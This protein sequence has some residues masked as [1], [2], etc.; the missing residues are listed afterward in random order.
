MNKYAAIFFDLDGTLRANQPEGFEAF[1]EYAAQ[2]GIMLTVEQV[3]ICEREAHRYWADGALV[4]DHQARY[5]ERGFWINYNNV[6]LNAMGIHDQNSAAEKIQNLFD[7]YY[8]QDIVF[9]DTSVVLRA[10][11]D[12]GY[13]LG[14]V[15]NR[16]GDLAPL[17]T[18]YGLSEYF[19]FTLSGGQAQSFKPDPGIFLQSLQMAGN[20]APEQTLFVGDSYYAD[21]LGALG[22]RMNALL[23]DRHDIFQ[24]FYPK[25]VKTLQGVLPFL[26]LQQLQQHD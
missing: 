15:S 8:P 2:V 23:I 24:D 18:Q 25:R 1:V 17:V 4:S 9:P 16:D 26:G 13:I 10:L 19:L 6:L 14:L 20:V 21:I 11:H 12:A 5:D 22:V 7:H 3:E